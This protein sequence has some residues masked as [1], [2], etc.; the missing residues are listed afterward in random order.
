M[1]KVRWVTAVVFA[2]LIGCYL[3]KFNAVLMYPY[4]AARAKYPSVAMELGT[5][6]IMEGFNVVIQMCIL[7]GLVLASPFIASF[8]PTTLTMECSSNVTFTVV[9]GGSTPLVYQW[10]RGASPILNAT[11][12]TF[13]SRGDAVIWLTYVHFGM[14]GKSSTL[15]QFLPPSSVICSRPSSVPTKI[16]PSRL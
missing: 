16:R 10:F 9:A 14:P 3:E 7:G 6:T 2:V 4:D 11:N 12:T 15:R 8:S 13:A 1:T 5:T